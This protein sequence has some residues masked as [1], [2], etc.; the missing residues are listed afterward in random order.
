[1]PHERAVEIVLAGR[2]THFDPDV[3]DAFIAMGDEIRAIAA[4]FLDSEEAMKEA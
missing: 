1:M 2:G 3:V 4:R